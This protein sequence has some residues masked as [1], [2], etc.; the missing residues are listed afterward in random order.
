MKKI[1]LLLLAGGA[2][3]QQIHVLDLMAGGLVHS[4]YD[5][6]YY[7][8]LVAENGTNGNHLAKISASGVVQQLIPFTEN[9]GILAISHD[10]LKIYCVL[11]R[12]YCRAPR[13]WRINCRFQTKPE[14]CA[15]ARRRGHF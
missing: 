10:G 5:Q 14:P 1:L 6:M 8:S 7:A 2:S 4:P 15:Q 12:R 9:P 3:A 13:I 11:C